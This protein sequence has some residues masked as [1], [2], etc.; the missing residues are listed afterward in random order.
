MNHVL[1]SGTENQ[2]QSRKALSPKNRSQ[3]TK[4]RPPHLVFDYIHSP[5]ILRKRREDYEVYLPDMRI[6]L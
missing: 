5:D 3:D 2:K 1:C 4:N 6:C